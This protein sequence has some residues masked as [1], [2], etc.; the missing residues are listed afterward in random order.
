MPLKKF[1]AL[2]YE[3][4]SSIKLKKKKSRGEIKSQFRLTFFCFVAAVFSEKGSEHYQNKFI[5]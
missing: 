2:N 4:L 5:F 1:Y 3:N